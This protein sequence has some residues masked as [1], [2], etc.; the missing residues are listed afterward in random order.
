MKVIEVYISCDMVYR[1][2]LYGYFLLYGWMQVSFFSSHSH[3]SR[4]WS[5]FLRKNAVTNTNVYAFLT[6]DAVDMPTKRCSSPPVCHFSS[7]YFSLIENSELTAFT[8]VP[9]RRRSNVFGQSQL[10]LRKYVGTCLLMW[11]LSRLQSRASEPRHATWIHS[12]TF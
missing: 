12:R 10:C 4:S 5:A 9:K 3:V 2:G 11:T 8:D 1:E 6:N 7:R